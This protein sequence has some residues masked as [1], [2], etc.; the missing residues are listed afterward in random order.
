MTV[1]TMERWNQ[2]RMLAS[3]RLRE[4][5]TPIHTRLSKQ[6]LHAF[7]KTI[8]SNRSRILEKTLL[9]TDADIISYAVNNAVVR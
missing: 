4:L 2:E 9:T 8:S 7:V 3:E 6:E 1:K 5:L